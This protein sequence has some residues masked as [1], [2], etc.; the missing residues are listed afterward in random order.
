MQTYPKH[1]AIIPDGN[2]TRAKKNKKDA[3]QWH[4]EWVERGVELISYSLWQTNIEVITG[5]WLSTENTKKRSVEERTYLFSL[6]K[7]FYDELDTLL[8]QHKASFHWIGNPEWM[9]QDFVAYLNEKKEKH[10]Y[11][12]HDNTNK[13][14]QK[15]VC[16]AFNYWGQ[17]E[18]IR[19]VQA[20]AQSWIDMTK[21][22]ADQL[23]TFTDLGSLPPVDLVIRTKADTAQRLSGFASRSWWYAELFFSEHAFPD[24][25]VD[26]YKKALSR[27][28]LR[29]SQRN[30]WA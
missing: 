17:D 27:Y 3:I 21:I 14:K 10:N 2:R 24:F 16:L 1:I 4:L 29:Q 25:T 11:T 18:I 23:T 30:F 19:A 7:K 12:K 28:E 8:I 26:E 5:R 9:P 20:A 6:Y 13:N 22:T 15:T